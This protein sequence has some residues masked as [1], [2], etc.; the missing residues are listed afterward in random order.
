MS[1]LTLMDELFQTVVE[2]L[3]EKLR[4]GEATA[5]DVKN[6][7]QFLK[8]NDITVAAENFPLHEEIAEALKDAKIIPFPS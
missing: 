1:R 2:Q 6:A 7:I 5:S 4:S 3:I 8:D